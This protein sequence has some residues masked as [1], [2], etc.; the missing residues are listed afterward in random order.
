MYSEHNHPI[1]TY[2]PSEYSPYKDTSDSNSIVITVHNP[3]H[4]PAVRVRDIEAERPQQGSRQRK[5]EFE[6][7]LN[8]DITNISQFTEAQIEHPKTP[9]NHQIESVDQQD[10]TAN[11]I[12][13]LCAE[14]Y[15]YKALQDPKWF[16]RE[17]IHDIEKI[18]LPEFFEDGPLT[19]D[20]YIRYRNC[21]IDT[22]KSNPEYY[23]TVSH[24]KP[25]LMNVDLVTLVRIHNF[26]ES[27]RLI[28]TM[29]DPRRRIFDPYIDSSPELCIPPGSQRDFKDISKPDIQYLK[30]LVY[31]ISIAKNSKEPW[32]LSIEDPLNPDNRKKYNCSTCN[33]DCSEIRYQSLKF[34]HVQVC[35]N[36]F[37]EGRYSAVLS[38]GDFLRIDDSG[39]ELNMDDE[40]TDMEILR[41]LEGIEK[42][43]DDW[44]LIS[45]HVGSRTKEQCITQFLQLPINDDFLST[46]PTDSEMKEVPFGESSNPVM[47]MIAFLSGHVNSGVASAAAKSAM[48]ILIKSGEGNAT[49]ERKSDNVKQEEMDIDSLD[50]KGKELERSQPPEENK[51]AF[52]KETMHKATTTA[53]K[54]AIETARKLAAYENEEIQHWARLAVKTTVEKLSLKL[55]QYDAL[56]TSLENEHEEMEK[57]TSILASSID[58]LMAQH[59]PLTEAEMPTT[60]NAFSLS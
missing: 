35:V 48:Q 17:S 57:Q 56:E 45:E 16:D 39:A 41:L 40:W 51:G 58:T 12:N 6:P 1:N 28:N 46:I 30:D 11:I 50:D 4:E 18:A 26:L 52:S 33:T 29:N 2:T 23:I 24:C 27:N 20:D 32:N 31:D 44:L 22:Y 14:P 43:D 15:D 36:C 5:N 54:A 55:Q 34:K 59:H 9:R 47:T 49:E 3:G 19:S 25:K 13:L 37:L 7:Y 21:I 8:G 42:Y 10:K 38:S 60:N 53:L